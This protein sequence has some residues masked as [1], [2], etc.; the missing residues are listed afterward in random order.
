MK[1]IFEEFYVSDGNVF[2]LDFEKVFENLKL[3]GEEDFLG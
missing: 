2:L 3:F 1:E